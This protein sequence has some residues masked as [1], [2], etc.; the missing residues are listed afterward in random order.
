[1]CRKPS[2]L[3]ERERVCGSASGGPKK[4]RAAL[5]AAEGL[6][7]RPARGGYWPAPLRL[8]EALTGQARQG[9]IMHGLHHV[10]VTA[11]SEGEAEAKAYLY[12]AIESLPA[13]L[14]PTANQAIG[15]PGS[16]APAMPPNGNR[17]RAKC[18][19]ERCSNT[20]SSRSTPGV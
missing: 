12:C 20:F 19:G 1:M 16:S 14:L 9:F 5:G 2:E 6:H 10:K 11:N 17:R 7:L 15:G 3:R 8:T 4:K 18:P 13:A